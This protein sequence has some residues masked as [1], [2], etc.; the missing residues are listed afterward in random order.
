[1]LLSGSRVTISN[2]VNLTADKKRNP[3]SPYSYRYH[4][5]CYRCSQN[6]CQTY[7]CRVHRQAS[8]TIQLGRWLGP[9]THSTCR[10]VS[11]HT[12]RCRNCGPAQAACTLPSSYTGCSWCRSQGTWA[13]SCLK[14]VVQYIIVIS[15]VERGGSL[16]G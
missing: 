5:P 10:S 16:H 15:C 8:P 3:I 2:W 11:P 9:G 1:M 6:P 14:K 13:Q 12:R 4:Y 7:S